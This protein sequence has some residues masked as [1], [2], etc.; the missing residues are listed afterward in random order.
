MLYWYCIYIRDILSLCLIKIG[1]SISRH[2]FF[3]F[4]HQTAFTVGGQGLIVNPYCVNLYNLRFWLLWFPLVMR[5]WFHLFGKRRFSAVHYGTVRKY[6]KTISIIVH[7]LLL[8]SWNYT[9]FRCFACFS[10]SSKP[11]QIV[12]Q[13]SRTGISGFWMSLYFSAICSGVACVP[14]WIWINCGWSLSL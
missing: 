8:L 5:L 1:G 14:V 3:H 4:F 12:C 13:L 11:F 6:S 7:P 9:Q 2:P 10:C